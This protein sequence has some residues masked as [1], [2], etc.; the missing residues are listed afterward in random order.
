LISA[1]KRSTRRTR[2]VGVDGRRLGQV[3]MRRL[4]SIGCFEHVEPGHWTEP[5]VGGSTPVIIRMVVVL[6]APLGPG[7]QDFALLDLER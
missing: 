3:P 1:T 7:S 5:E 6:P 4:T 2:H